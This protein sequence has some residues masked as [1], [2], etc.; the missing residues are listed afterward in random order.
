MAD[1]FKIIM[2]VGALGLILLILNMLLKNAGL[3]VVIVG[4]GAGGFAFAQIMK[5]KEKTIE[6]PVDDRLKKFAES[7]MPIE[8][9]GIPIFLES[10]GKIGSL[11][12]YAEVKFKD[13]EFAI[14]SVE[15]ASGMGRDIINI[16]LEKTL[17]GRKLGVW[18]IE[19]TALAP[20]SQRTFTVNTGTVREAMNI[21]EKEHD[22]GLVME[23]L[24]KSSG[25]VVGA[26]D[27]NFAVKLID[28]MDKK[29]VRL[30]VTSLPDI[31][32]GG[33]ASKTNIPEVKK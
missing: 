31:A 12:G 18:A 28:S 4:A 8:L 19:A 7:N 11:K 17:V 3:L 10:G 20:I 23:L 16:I 32:R 26:M 33:E 29:V 9:K 27:A 14:M 2:R 15:R 21:Y 1:V 24:K 6:I 22:Q 25:M 13:K 5:N 30:P